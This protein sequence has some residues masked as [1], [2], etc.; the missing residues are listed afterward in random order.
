MKR[1][2]EKI[3]D[4][5]FSLIE[6]IVVIIVIV[7][8]TAVGITVY[9]KVQENA[10]NS[11]NGSV[12]SAQEQ[13]SESQQPA[14]P[15]NWT[16]L[17]IGA[18]ALLGVAAIGGGGYVTYS[19]V[20]AGKRAR[21]EKKELL[22]KESATKNEAIR[23][24]DTMRDTYQRI[25]SRYA[26]YETDIWKALKYPSLH[27][28]TVDET[29]DFLKQLRVVNNALKEQEDTEQG[30]IGGTEDLYKRI[31]G[32]VNQLVSL[33]ELAENKALKME[34][35]SLPA[36]ERK[37]LKRATQLLKHAENDG[38]SEAARRSYY[39]QL[40]KVVDRLNARHAHDVIPTATIKLLASDEKKP[41][42]TDGSD[43]QVEEI[44]I[45]DSTE[46][47]RVASR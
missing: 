33:F 21:R 39:E 44:N 27:D 36:D 24:W 3:D 22:A 28:A 14:E 43:S 46:K 8:L 2:K 10:E 4:S 47:D 6:L 5:G 15:V 12:S 11:E 40:Q 30:S 41:Q 26:E 35:K 18:G 23:R 25:V 17:V 20:K 9:G 7:M 31:S 37:D 29:S 38:N 45:I 1:W 13:N 34:W 19:G 42:I 16:P 32:E